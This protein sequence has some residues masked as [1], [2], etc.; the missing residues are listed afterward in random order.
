[1]KKIIVIC[2]VL[3]V[4]VLGCRVK[5]DVATT[6]SESLNATEI[7]HVEGSSPFAIDNSIELKDSLFASI[8]KGLC[9][10]NCPTYNMY[11]Y[12]NG[13]IVLKAI[14]GVDK[15]GLYKASLQPEAMHEFISKAKEIH[16]FEMKEVYDNKM[17]TDLPMVITSIVIEGKRK[18]V[19]RRYE[20][21]KEIV[22]L[23]KLFTNLLSEL[24][25]EKIQDTSNN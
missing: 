4:A 1:M 7:N 3:V 13:N 19:K 23:E 15:K 18:V 21:P 24:N 12:N 14:R 17:V 11:I 16:F 9:F 22:E 20:Y 2:V 10:G 6:G 5:S 25:W 8:E